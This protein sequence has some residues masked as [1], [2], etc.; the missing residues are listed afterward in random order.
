MRV[1]ILNVLAQPVA[2]RDV[3]FMVMRPAQSVQ[4]LAKAV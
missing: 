4:S 3:R 2:M 1:K